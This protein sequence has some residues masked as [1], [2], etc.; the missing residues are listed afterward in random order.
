MTHSATRSNI[1]VSI[2]VRPMRPELRETKSAWDFTPTT[3]RERANPDSFFTFD[4]IYDT[5]STTRSLY[6]Q[7]VKSII[8][9]RVAQGYNG[10]VFAYGQTGSGKSYT[11]LGDGVRGK[12]E[13]IV[14][15][16][17][18]DLFAELENEQRRKP[19]VSVEV[20]VSELEIYN[21]Q[22]RDLLVEPGTVAPALSI[23]ENDYGVYVHNAIKRKVH[24]AEEC[25]RLIHR[26]AESRVSAS[27]A[28]NERSSRSH[29]VIRVVVEKTITLFVPPAEDDATATTAGMATDQED[30]DDD[31]GDDVESLTSVGTSPVSSSP[32][33]G[34]GGGGGGSRRKP[35]V[36]KILST[37]NLVDLA[38]SER[39]SKTGATGLRMIEGGH[40][41]KSLTILTTVINRLTEPGTNNFVPYRDSRLTH[42]LKTA[43]GGNSFTSVFCCITPAVENVDESRST[44][45]FASR[46][47]RIKNSVVVNE[48]ADPKLKIRELEIEVRRLRR[49]LVASTLY[50]WSKSLKIE[51]LRER[52]DRAVPGEA[53]GGTGGAA[54]TGPSASSLSTSAAAFGGGG[55]GDRGGLQAQQRMIME[56]LRAQNEA[57][58]E[59][60]DKTKAALELQQQ[61][62]TG[63]STNT[64]VTNDG[65]GSAAA[66]NAQRMAAL[67]ADDDE[68]QQMRADLRDLETML[69]EAQEEKSA[70]EHDLNELDG[71][72]RELEGENA[73]QAASIRELTEKNTEL[74][75]LLEDLDADAT[76]ARHEQELLRSQLQKTQS[77]LLEKSRGDAY[78]EELTKV[79]IEHQ[80]LQFTF[81]Q[82][83]EQLERERREHAN[84]LSALQDKLNDAEDEKGELTDRSEVQNSYL[85]RLLSAATLATT[86]KVVDPAD[87]ASPVRDAQVAAAIRALTNLSVSGGGGGGGTSTPQQLPA[88]A[89]SRLEDAGDVLASSRNW[90]TSAA[91]AAFA[92]ASRP[93]LLNRIAQLEQQLVIKDAQRDVIVDTKLKRMQEL[94]LRLHSMNTALVKELTACY[95]DNGR[96]FQ[97]MDKYPK[98]APK[99]SKAGLFPR[100][101]KA[102]LDHARFAK[103]PEKPLGHN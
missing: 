40:I 34:G 30:D 3:A 60:L 13:G 95:E 57:L 62:V 102:A 41:N 92:G 100:S 86:G 59:E 17:V 23:R 25:V 45:Q 70:V 88:S 61:S 31:T 12:A 75:S 26:Q 48:L 103:P 35:Q 2:R 76:A 64:S 10:T 71:L 28:M 22:L 8:V 56:Q 101:L 84:A 79:H 33:G 78:L 18:Y 68:K 21:E 16:A 65:A 11:M 14:T 55:G 47:K 67:L 98:L 82:L 7:S 15:L 91:A 89:S 50:L 63:L 83:K 93:E 74:E 94:A 5:H 49:L 29:C 32:E 9:S 69:Q 36:K 53:G 90:R 24:S 4:H 99:L 77:K 44:L 54:L 19:H 6:E 52:L 27:T 42:L 39:V 73:K 58:Q 37:L 87:M 38:G 51:H 97:L 80:D 81:N 43:I 1:E 72:C 46:A 66:A 85:W 96:L 20:F